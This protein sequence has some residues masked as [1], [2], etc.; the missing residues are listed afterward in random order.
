[1]RAYREE[2]ATGCRAFP[3]RKAFARRPAAATLSKPT[4]VGL[5][6]DGIGTAT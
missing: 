5:T 4:G 1:M 3:H 6:A 2:S